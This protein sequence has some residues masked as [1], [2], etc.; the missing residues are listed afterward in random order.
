MPESLDA[1][2]ARRQFSKG[3]SI[4]YELGT[5]RAEWEQY[6]ALIRQYHPELNRFVTLTQIPPAAEV[7][8]VWECEAGHRFVATPGEQRN[9]PS[10]ERRRSSWCPDC[11]ALAVARPK[12]RQAVTAAT[13][14]EVRVR[15]PCGHGTYRAT[16]NPAMCRVCRN[17]AAGAD[18][19]P[20]GTAFVSEWAPRRA[21][22]IEGDLKQR[23]SLRYDFDLSF[24]AIRVARPFFTHLEVWPD[25]V[26]SEL[27]VAIELDTVGRHGL[28]HVGKREVVDRRKDRLLRA[29]GWEVIRIRLGKLQPLGPYDVC[30][31]GLTKA[32]MACLDDR[33]GEVRGDLFLSAYRRSAVN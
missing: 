10:G 23:M 8:L 28:E 3:R 9:R 31:S 13:A 21:S 5:Y 18:R 12:R 17:A 19:V 22:V 25:L 20:V 30:A 2:W 6:P 4:P 24:N 26:I 29:T 7:L 11:S 32:L 1:W 16:T 15:R 27:S 14:A 33:L